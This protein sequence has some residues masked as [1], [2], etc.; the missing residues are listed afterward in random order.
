MKIKNTILLIPSI[1]LLFSCAS[2]KQESLSESEF[3]IP[4]ETPYQK[5]AEKIFSERGGFFKETTDGLDDEASNSDEILEVVSACRNK[6]ISKGLEVASENYGKFKSWPTYWNA[7]GICYYLNKDLYKAKL[8]FNRAIEEDKRYAPAF[9]N[10][11]L[12]LVEKEEWENSL[13][14]FKE[15]LKFNGNSQVVNYNI[16]RLYLA[17]GHGDLALKHFRKV[18]DSQFYK[19]KLA[20]YMGVAHALAGEYSKAINILESLYEENSSNELVFLYFAYSLKNTGKQVRAK[21][22]LGDISIASRN[23]NYPLF[24]DLK[25]ELK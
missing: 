25:R 24:Y 23:P 19:A 10:L 14:A 6:N 15:A 2:T 13:L 9:N 7:I 16:G 5:N 22:V 20:P 3:N 1:F 18:S 21:K 12:L 11:G 8:Y 17:F 4:K